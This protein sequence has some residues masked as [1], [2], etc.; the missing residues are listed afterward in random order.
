MQKNTHTVAR[1]W[2][3]ININ[4]VFNKYN[5]ENKQKMEHGKVVF[6]KEKCVTTSIHITVCCKLKV[7]SLQL[8]TFKHFFFHRFPNTIRQ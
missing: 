8:Q 6:E 5:L 1:L 2:Q 3:V 7:R 4:F